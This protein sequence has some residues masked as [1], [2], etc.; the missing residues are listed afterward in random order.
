[1]A[2]SSDTGGDEGRAELDA[3]FRC[4]ADGDRRRL[5]RVV[6][7]RAPE[8]ATLRDLATALVRSRD[9]APPTRAPDAVRRATV[10]L[11]HVQLPALEAAGLVELG[12]DRD[13]VAAAD[14]PAFRDGGVVDVVRGEADAEPGSLDAL[15]G[16]LADSRRR[17]VLDVLGHQFGPIH[18]ETLARELG[19]RERGT[20][21]SAVPGEAVEG[22]L[23]SLR[24]R[25]LPRLAAPGL[26]EYDAEE[27][28]VEYVGHPALRAPWLHSVLEP[29][30]RAS[31]TGES[32]PGAVG[33]IEGRERVVSFAQALCDRADDELFCLFADTGMLEAGWFSR[34]RDA[35]R[36]GVDVYLGT[37]DPDVRELVREQ[38]PAVDLWAPDADWLSRPV[39]GRTV[40][41]LLL[42]DRE[43]VVVGTRGP[44]DGDDAP[45]EKA[46]VGEGTDNALVVMIGQMVTPH[47][48]GL[49]EQADV[50]ES[51][52]PF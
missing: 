25:H 11:Y 2:V 33:A 45:A 49:D 30:F 1:M 35:S 31:L 16:A 13:T 19:A 3:L 24:H 43:A 20:P 29:D 18:T 5:L 48:D 10:G 51:H 26:V 32:E 15:F 7:D 50:V 37:R 27:G 36:R 39:D 46:I 21:G 8:P 28:L 14:H 34:I 38:A 52:L 42:A 17:T 22:L 47:L 44:A 9:G 6:A 40:G 12:P 4:L 41:R 23:A